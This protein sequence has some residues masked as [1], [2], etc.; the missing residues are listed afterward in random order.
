MSFDKLWRSEFFNKVSAKDTVKDK[1][2]S[3]VKLNIKG[4]Y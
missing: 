4:T 2:L 3:Q 1:D